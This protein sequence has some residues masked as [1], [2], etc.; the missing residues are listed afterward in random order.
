MG[1]LYRVNVHLSTISTL[2]TYFLGVR[3]LERENDDTLSFMCISFPE[4]VMS[5]GE[6]LFY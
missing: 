3:K 5:I 2:H 4:N 1:F 6:L